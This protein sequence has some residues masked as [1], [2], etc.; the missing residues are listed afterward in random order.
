MSAPTTQSS[1][2]QVYGQLAGNLA[3]RIVEAYLA[4]EP[5]AVEAYAKW[6][7][8]GEAPVLKIT[9]FEKVSEV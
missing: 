7:E 8:T 9:G 5:G 3:M 6:K 4:G 2:A 1:L